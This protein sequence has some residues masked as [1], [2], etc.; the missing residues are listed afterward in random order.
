MTSIRGSVVA[1]AIVAALG[2]AATTAGAMDD[3]TAKLQV[4]PGSVSRGGAYTLRGSGW[5]AGC[6]R[7]GLVTGRG[8]SLG[9]VTPRGGAFT[10]RHRIAR[11]ARTG[12]FTITG[13]Q[14]CDDALITRVVTLR[15][16]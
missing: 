7:V 6:G 16:R 13:S 2:A 14:R 5:Q 3:G 4:S 15:V 12:S 1:G 8:R 10:V 9:R 11:A